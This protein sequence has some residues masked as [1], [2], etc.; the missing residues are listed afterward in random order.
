MQKHRGADSFD[1]SYLFFITYSLF[2]EP[3]I[4]EQCCGFLVRVE[5]KDAGGLLILVMSFTRNNP[6]ISFY[7]IID[8]SVTMIYMSA[9]SLAIF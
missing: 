1:I 9:P 4:E 5:Q 6:K 3:S 7:N 8:Q 2:L